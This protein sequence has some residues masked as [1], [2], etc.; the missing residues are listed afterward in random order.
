MPKLP[1]APRGLSPEA[2]KW[3]KKLLEEYSIEDQAGLLI[4]QVAL[5][6]FDRMRQ[7]QSQVEKD[8]PTILDRFDQ[9][10]AHPM[11]TV[12]RDARSQMMQALKSLNL[13]FEPLKEGPGRPAGN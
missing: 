3:W 13:D 11:L 5:E 10:K 8:G 7:A 2:R 9:L 4:L 6:A 12:E 1:I